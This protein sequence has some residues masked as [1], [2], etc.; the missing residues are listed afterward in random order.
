MRANS[1][2]LLG[3]EYAQAAIQRINER[4]SFTWETHKND[5]YYIH[6]CMHKHSTHFALYCGHL[7]SLNG[8]ER[9]LQCGWHLDSAFNKRQ[10]RNC[11]DSVEVVYTN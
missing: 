2:K 3:F 6:S 5:H 4:K 10:Q 8:L 11:L 1:S 7:F 9:S